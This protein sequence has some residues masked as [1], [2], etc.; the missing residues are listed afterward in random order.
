MKILH[1]IPAAFEY[2]EDVK[3][4]AFRIVESQNE[5]GAHA[6]AFA[7]QYSSHDISAENQKNK[8]KFTKAMMDKNAGRSAKFPTIEYKGLQAIDK[9]ISCFNDYD[10]VHLHTP[11]FGAGRKILKWKKLNPDKKFVI[12]F[13]VDFKSKDLFSFFIKLYNSYYLPRLFKIA[14]LLIGLEEESFFQTFAHHYVDDFDKMVFMIDKDSVDYS[15]LT[16]KE[17]GVKLSSEEFAKTLAERMIVTY[18]K[19]LINN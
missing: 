5:V 10:I 7:L 14:D 6:D 15:K 11:F 19:L 1:I 2:F 3:K 9:S 13:Y 8:N 17:N 4:V 18:Q 12:S 16:I